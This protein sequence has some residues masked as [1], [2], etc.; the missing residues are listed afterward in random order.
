VPGWIGP[1]YGDGEPDGDA[2]AEVEGLGW[3]YFPT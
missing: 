3:V 1:V 2:E